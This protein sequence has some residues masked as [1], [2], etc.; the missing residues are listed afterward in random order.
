MNYNIGKGSSSD[1]LNESGRLTESLAL[2]RLIRWQ[3][4]RTKDSE[5]AALG[6]VLVWLMAPVAA[7]RLRYGTRYFFV[8]NWYLTHY[9]RRAYLKGQIASSDSRRPAK[10]LSVLASVQSERE[11]VMNGTDLFDMASLVPLTSSEQAQL[12]AWA[13][14]EATQLVRQYSDLLEELREF[15]SVGSSSVGECVEFLEQELSL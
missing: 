12:L 14:D 6:R 13:Y 11:A 2:N 10:V 15:V 4:V 9:F 7:E 5:L 3:E 8:V 1:T